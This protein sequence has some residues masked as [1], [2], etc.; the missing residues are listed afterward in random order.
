M[1]YHY[2]HTSQLVNVLISS[3][4]FTLYINEYQAAIN[5]SVGVVKAANTAASFTS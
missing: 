3:K 2:Q 1:F 4:T 5:K